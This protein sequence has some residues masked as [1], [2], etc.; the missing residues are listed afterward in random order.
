MYHSGPYLREFY[1]RCLG[2]IQKLEMDYEFIFVND[3]S[4]DDSLAV[5]L[6]LK[7]AD[8]HVRV[9]DLSRNFGHHRAILTGLAYAS[10]E[11]I[12]L[13]DCDLEEPPEALERFYHVLVQRADVDVVFGVQENRKG[14]FIE[15]RVGGLYYAL[16]N[17]FSNVKIVPNLMIARL[18]RRDYV[19]ALVS[20]RETDLVFAGVAAHAGFMQLP[21]ALVK[22]S[23]GKTTYNLRRKMS[24]IVDSISSFS[25]RPLHLIFF[26]GLGLSGFSAVLMVYLVVKKLAY[27][28]VLAGWTSLLVSI[29]FLGGMVLLSIGVI[30]IYL[31]KIFNQVK[32]RPFSIV[33]RFYE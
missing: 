1:S 2:Q 13:I 21:V 7:A 27:M 18:M 14:G 20:Y 6:K 25:A 11:L 8:S 31:E 23:K 26:L 10:K 12:F 5:A 28:Q 9:V 32:Q 24:I 17:F 16:F 29:W 4:P 15:R 19:K 30:G 22:H 3:G 33:K